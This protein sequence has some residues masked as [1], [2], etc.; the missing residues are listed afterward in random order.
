MGTANSS[1]TRPGRLLSTIHP[2][3]EPDRLPHVVCHEDNG[4]SPAGADPVELVVEQ[5]PGHRV[6]RAERLVHQQHVG[7]L[8]QRAGQRH[9]LPH[10]AGQLVRPFPA[11]ADQVHRVQEFLGP[12]AALGPADAAGLEGKLHIAGG[13]E[14]GEQRGLLEHERHPARHRHLAFPEPLPE[15]VVPADEEVHPAASIRAA[16]G[17]AATV[18]RRI[19]HS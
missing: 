17:I 16:P 1:I 4:Q 19:P 6:Q 13:G 3:A 9:P 15:L 11:E 5:V 14:P 12:L 18:T 10:A 8:G 7:F 2:V